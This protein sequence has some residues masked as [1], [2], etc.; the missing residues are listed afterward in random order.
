MAEKERW[1]GRR[2]RTLS[3]YKMKFDPDEVSTWFTKFDIAGLRR[4]GLSQRE[5]YGRQAKQ[6][7]EA[8]K[9]RR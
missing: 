4:R 9:R 5:A 3:K 7:R 2:E 8:R 6:A 1:K